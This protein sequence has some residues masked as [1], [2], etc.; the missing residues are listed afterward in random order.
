MKEIG[1]YFEL[2]M[3]QYNVHSGLLKRIPWVNDSIANNIIYTNSGRHALEYILRYSCAGIQNILI[4]FY[5]CDSI[6]P[7]IKRS[8]YSY[9]FYNIN[10]S[11]EISNIPDLDHNSCILVNNYF[12]LKDAYVRSLAEVYGCRVIID[13]TQAWYAPPIHGINTF[14]SPRKYFGLPDGGIAFVNTPSE[15]EL[16]IGTSWHRCSHLL[17]RIDSGATSGYADFKQNSATIIDEPILRMSALT[18][19]LLLS[20][21]FV[22]AMAI[23]RKNFSIIAEALDSINELDIPDYSSYSCPM[24]YPFLTSNPDIR[25]E[26]ISNK[27]YVATY[28]PNVLEWCQPNSIEQYLTNHLIPIPIDQRYGEEDMERIISIIKR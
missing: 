14:Y 8:E 11:L 9:K 27:I 22:K 13:N 26:L 28:W 16:E 6:I 23:R 21:D 18:E 4:P 10:T 24:V 15:I 2:E 12:G 3:P 7:S 19:T 20:I 17:K 5:T 1:G 25:H